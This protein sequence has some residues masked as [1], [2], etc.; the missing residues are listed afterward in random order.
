MSTINIGW[1]KNKNGE[2]FAPKTL[3]SQVV[4]SD[5]ILLEDKIQSDID[6]TLGK[7]DKLSE[8]KANVVVATV[9]GEQFVVTDS[10]NEKLRGMKL[11]GKSGQTQ[12]SGKN[13]CNVTLKD[14]TINGVTFTVND[15]G[16]VTANGTCTNDIYMNIGIALLEANVEYR[17]SGCPKLVVWNDAGFYVN[18]NALSGNVWDRGET[19]TFIMANTQEYPC[20]L[21]LRKDV[22]YNN[23][24]FYPMIRLSS[25]TDK[26]FEPYTGGIASPNPQ[27][28][29]EIESSGDDGFVEV[30]FV[31]RNIADC[32]DAESGYP[33]ST[34]GDTLLLNQSVASTTYR[35]CFNVLKDKQYVVT[36]KSNTPISET[37]RVSVITDDSLKVVQTF[38]VYVKNESVSFIANQDGIVHLCMDNHSTDIQAEY[39]SSGTSYESYE[40][41][42]R[43]I[44]TPNGLCGILVT[45]ATVATYIDSDGQMWCCDEID[46]EEG[47]YIERLVCI[48]LDGTE[49]WGQTGNNEYRC[50]FENIIPRDNFGGVLCTHYKPAPKNQRNINNTIIRG[51]NGYQIFICDERFGGD[52]EAFKTYIAS[53]KANGTPVKVL[54]QRDDFVKTK[55]STEEIEYYK[56]IRMGYLS[57]TVKSDSFVKVD[58][59]ADT[60]RYI[61]NKFAELATALVAMG[62]A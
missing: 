60:K 3:V 29:Q 21:Q 44:P 26:T 62:G 54:C 9:T 14:Q 39:G 41:Q 34:V 36:W 52:V 6:A 45:D 10:A 13:L 8:D 31:G 7:V 32:S 15:D 35:N 51:I 30:E 61:D 58:Y 37:M 23:V 55:L 5:G 19:S 40:K 1:L 17:I 22:V 25:N 46:L 27:Y 4:T 33:N 24:I 38:N 42:S 43:V 56:D 53:E 2:K 18:S 47:T 48:T 28:P 59:L 57:T 49:N 20:T 50:S 11:F 12:Y 16:S